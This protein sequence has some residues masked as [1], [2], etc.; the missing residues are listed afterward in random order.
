M[1]FAL[2]GAWIWGANPAAQGEVLPQNI[3]VSAFSIAYSLCLALFGGTT[4]VVAAYL[5]ERTA[6][7]FAPVWYLVGLSAISLIA[8]FSISETPPTPAKTG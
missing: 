7:D 5:L 1:G 8:A 3:R 6:D 2:I 4:P